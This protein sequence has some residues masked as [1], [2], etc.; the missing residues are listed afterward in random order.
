[1]PNANETKTEMKP[2]LSMEDGTVYG[3]ISPET[4]KPMFVAP[5]IDGLK[6]PFN[7]A[8][9][10]SQKFEFNGKNDFRPASAK[11]MAVLSKNR[12]KGALKRMFDGEDRFWTST[13][14]PHLP[15]MAVCHRFSDGQ[16]DHGPRTKPMAVALVRG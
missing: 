16:Q 6:L 11:E 8:V 7:E 10:Y 5:K 3:G 1:M 12:N 9:H 15:F 2:G 13:A 4:G 14:L